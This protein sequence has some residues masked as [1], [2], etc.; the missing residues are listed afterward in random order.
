MKLEKYYSR[1]TTDDALR[2]MEHYAK[3]QKDSPEVKNAVNYILMGVDLKDYKLVF[4]TIRNFIINNMQYV[5]DGEEAMQFG[6][7]GSDL[8]LIKSPRA[9]LESGRYD[10][11]CATTLIASL[12]L[13]IGIPV[14]FVVISTM[15]YEMTGPEGWTHV[16][17]EGYD[18][19]EKKW[20]IIDPVSHPA[21]K[22]MILDTKQHKIYNLI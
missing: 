15:P 11:D 6:F 20:I 16:Y 17:A 21:E 4:A 19:I 3:L 10:C 12:L 9:I 22:Q 7:D 2:A 1:H 13:S 5:P 14:R 18:S 8:E